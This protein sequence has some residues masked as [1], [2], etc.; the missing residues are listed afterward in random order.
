MCNY[1][2]QISVRDF[3]WGP[4]HLFIL[5]IMEN[6]NRV[7][8]FLSFQLVL[9]GWETVGNVKREKLDPDMQLLLAAFSARPRARWRGVASDSA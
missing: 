4:R 6:E 7:L 3:G 9:Q 2:W 1:C 5:L 8:T